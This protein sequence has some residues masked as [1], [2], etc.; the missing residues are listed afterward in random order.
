VRRFTVKLAFS[1]RRFNTQKTIPTLPLMRES[2][3]QIINHL[4]SKSM[5]VEDG[6]VR[7]SLK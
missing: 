1:T 2:L 3:R 4:A 6:R 5:Q 7:S